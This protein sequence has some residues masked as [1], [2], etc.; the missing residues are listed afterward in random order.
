[1]PIIYLSRTALNAEGKAITFCLQEVSIP[2]RKSKEMAMK[3]WI[4]SYTAC[5]NT[6]YLAPVVI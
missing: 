6:A 3:K 5:L 4:L 2:L 1:M